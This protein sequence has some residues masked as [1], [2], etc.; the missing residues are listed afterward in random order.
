MPLAKNAYASILLMPPNWLGDVVMA[1]PAMRALA[2][3]F[4]DARIELFGHAWLQDL[5]P[6]LNLGKAS[7]CAA[8]APC[9]AAFILRNSFHAAWQAWRMRAANRYGFRHEGRGILLNHALQ[10]RINMK[11]EHHREYFLDLIEQAGIPVS[12]RQVNLHAPEVERLLGEVLLTEHG[13]D[14][15]KVICIAPG[16]QFGGAKRYPHHAYARIIAALA[17]QGW[18]PVILGTDAERNIGTDCLQNV[19]AASWNAAGKTSLRQALQ[20]IANTRLMLCNDSGLMHVAARLGRATI[21]IFGAT[22]PERT[23]PSG[24]HVSLLYQPADCSPCL[25]RECAVEGQPCM[26]NITP[27]TVIQHCLRL[28][29][30]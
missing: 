10:A 16:A 5:T 11:N 26:Q 14:V 7:F 21:G 4:P 28:L 17:E 23:A 27:E 9:E 15:E 3:H 2:E 8:P 24:Q 20:I 1:Q 13:L 19:A 18:Q 29:T 25:A 6:F 22:S 30:H 12:Q